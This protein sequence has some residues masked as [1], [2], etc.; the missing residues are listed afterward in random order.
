MFKKNDLIDV[1]IIDINSQG[2][3]VCKPDNYVVF[4]REGLIGDKLSIKLI[5]A[6]KKYGI[7]I[8]EKIIESSK[9]RVESFC[10]YG[11]QCGGCD[12]TNLD[13]NAQLKFKKEKVRETLKRIGGI[14]TDLDI[15]PSSH[16]Y[17]YRNKAQFPAEE[18]NGKLR[19]GFYRKKSHSII[20]IKSCPIQHEKINE[21]F[22]VVEDFLNKKG[23]PAYNEK[24]GKGVVRHLYIRYGFHTGEMMICLVINKNHFKEEKSFINLLKK[25]DYVKSAYINFNTRDTNVIMGEK[26]RLI[27]GTDFIEDTIGEYKYKISL[28]SFYQVNPYQTAKL[29]DKVLEFLGNENM[30]QVVDA[31]CGIGTITLPLSQSAKKVYGIEIVP[32]AIK[33]ANL[34]KEINGITNVE[35]I[36]GKSEEIIYEDRFRNIDTLVV[37]PPRKGLDEKFIASILENLPKK[38]VYV[39]CDVGTLARDLKILS[40][41][42]KVDKV[43]AVDQFCH[44]LH[45]E[46]VVL[47]SRIVEQV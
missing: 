34:N 8:I 18:I 39:S 46:T 23:I 13:Y 35:F 11:K 17:N 21:I 4:V 36:L 38:I 14:D 22:P 43:T 3:G 6:N 30:G 27:Y 40:S 20:P 1:E 15:I 31:Y 47:M 7:G 45:V 19:F 44:S 16:I 29:Y 25:Y 26:S 10:P 32:E 2:M 9:D 5:K 24:T 42:Y 28:K 37:D 33:D 12:F 41:D